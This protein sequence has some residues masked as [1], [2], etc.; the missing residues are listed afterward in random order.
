MKIQILKLQFEIQQLM[1]TPP[2]GDEQNLIGYW[3]FENTNGSIAIDASSFNHD[4]TYSGNSDI[5]LSNDTPNYQ[6]TQN[7]N[8][9]ASSEN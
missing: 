6:N 8:S 3:N 2:T 1:Q 5:P 9:Y 4:G 7:I